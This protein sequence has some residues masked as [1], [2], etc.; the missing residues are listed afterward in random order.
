MSLSQHLSGRTEEKNTRKTSIRI[1]S[2]QAECTVEQ[3]LDYLQV[4][5]KMFDVKIVEVNYEFALP[6]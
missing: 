5:W 6:K 3:F 2:L 4:L 1:A